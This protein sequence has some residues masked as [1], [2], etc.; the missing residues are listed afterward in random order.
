MRRLPALK[1]LQPKLLLSYLVVLSVGIGITVLA[2]GLI[3]PSMFDGL[4][5]DHMG[6]HSEMGQ[7]MSAEMQRDTRAVFQTALLRSL[8]I[9][10]GVAT[11]AAV[12]VSAF[13]AWRI[14]QPVQRIAAASR[15]IARGEYNERVPSASS[16]ELGELVTSF[17]AMAA[18]LEAAERQRIYLI[19]DIAHEI[20][21]PLTTLRG[22]LE[23]MIDGVIEPV[24]E[25]L[26]RLYDETAR[27]NRLIDDL[28]ELS[29]VESG[30]R[31][32]ERARLAPAA[33]VLQAIAAQQTT[34]GAR[35]VTLLTKIAGD[36]PLLVVDGDR[37]VQVL[38]NLLSNAVRHTPAGGT[39]SV[40][41]RHTASTVEIS[42]S[43]TGSGIAPEHLPQIFDRFY[44][45]DPARSR[46][47]GG[48]GIG[49][50]IAR[51]LVEA[52]GGSIRAS[53]PGVGHGTVV[54]ITLPVA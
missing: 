10:T 39:V 23:G 37:I 40:A 36:L 25:L 49:L 29:V 12:L 34:A 2:I 1:R 5:A 54:I 28:Q 46:Q 43:D 33:L 31:P 30:S 7:M 27:I 13:V 15:R 9:S 14:T 53:S 45:A 24:P 51:A 21:T 50:T 20:R 41:A 8:L 47:L 16:D 35:G 6:G 17:N 42:V 19:G 22:N 3:G 52:H 4:L 44:R 18:T 32:L 26:V 38:A 48:S 11:G